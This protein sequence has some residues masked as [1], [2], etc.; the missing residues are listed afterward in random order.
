M[1]FQLPPRSRLDPKRP[2][3]LTRTK[4]MPPFSTFYISE[5]SLALGN[6][7]DDTVDR[8]NVRE[9]EPAIPTEWSLS[10]LPSG[11][12]YPGST[13]RS[14][15]RGRRDPQS[16]EESLTGASRNQYRNIIKYPLPGPLSPHLAENRKLWIKMFVVFCVL[17]ITT[18]MGTMSIYWGGDHSLQYNIPVLTIAVI[19]FDHSEIGNYLQDMATAARAKDYDHSLGFVNQDGTSTYGNMD[20]VRASLHDQ[21]FWV[22]IVITENATN[23]M[24]H[25]YE[26]GDESYDPNSAIHVF[27]EEARNALVIGGA[28][29]PK[30]LDFLNEFVL[31]FSKQKQNTFLQGIDG[32]DMDA[33]Q[34]QVRNPVAA[35]FT[36]FNMAPAIPSTAEAA[37]E[38]GTIYL[39]IVSFL[40]VLMFDKVSDTIMGTIPMNIYYVYRLAVLPIVFLFLSLFYLTLSCMWH[41]PFSLHFGPAGY[42]LYWMLSW[43]SMMAFGL[44]I[45]NVNNILG[46]P[47]TPVFFVFWVISNVTTGFYPTEMLNDFYKWG[48]VWP[49]RHD[50]MGA[51]AIIY[52]TKNTLRQNFGVLIGWVLISLLLMPGTLWVQMRKKRAIREEKSKVILEK[53]WGAPGKEKGGRLK[54]PK[55]S[56]PK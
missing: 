23:A 49:L 55:L 29:Y 6:E 27:Y 21:K 54:L 13:I 20:N 40:S 22:G 34:R 41:I 15:I 48:I 46:M 17:L 45:E 33:L 8:K 32:S 51:R 50:M 5:E 28:V 18:I 37:T 16:D 10:V 56:P 25:A 26:I 24:N 31:E 2:F 30:L 12:R 1:P 7:T 47:F 14:S 9:N 53:V 38:I 19:D 36:V 4:R 3:Y 11:R 44:T 35:G 39:I 43:I 52:G 42:P